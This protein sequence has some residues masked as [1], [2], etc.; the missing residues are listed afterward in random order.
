MTR[1]LLCGLLL[2]SSSAAAEESTFSPRHV[3]VTGTSLA[4]VQP[5]MVVWH[6]T[7]RRTDRDLATALDRIRTIRLGWGQVVDRPCRIAAYLAALLR[8]G[9]WSGRLRRCS[10]A[11]PSREAVRVAGAPER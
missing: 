2:A 10:P 5:D 7:I 11:C 1:L 4:R 9:G 8:Q 3:S 6:V